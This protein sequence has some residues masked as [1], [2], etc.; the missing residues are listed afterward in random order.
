MAGVGHGPG[1]LAVSL[2]LVS[3]GDTV[4]LGTPK[5]GIGA[6]SSDVTYLVTTPASSWFVGSGGGGPLSP[7]VKAIRVWRWTGC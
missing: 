3:G 1:H 6:K 2:K 7:P 4:G 5:M